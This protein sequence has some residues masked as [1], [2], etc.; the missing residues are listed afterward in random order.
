[1]TERR[2]TYTLLIALLPDKGDP[3]RS[4]PRRLQLEGKFIYTLGV[5]YPKFS[6]SR[7]ILDVNTLIALTR[8]KILV[9]LYN[10]EAA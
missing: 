8:R 7:N 6:Y 1:M 10:R 9:D 2:I 4:L 5:V 3:D